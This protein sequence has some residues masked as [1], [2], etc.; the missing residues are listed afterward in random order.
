[1]GPILFLGILV[2]SLIY[3]AEAI[4]G[5]SFGWHVSGR[6]LKAASS[7]LAVVWFL[8][9]GARLITEFNR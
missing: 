2:V 4:S 7:L 6:T 5:R 1:M 8:Y 3:S 9:W